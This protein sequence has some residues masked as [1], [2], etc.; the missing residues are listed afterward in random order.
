MVTEL[1]QPGGLLLRRDAI[2]AGYTDKHLRRL[3]LAGRIERIRQ[4]A[5]A[6]SD[7]WNSLDAT[8][9]HD[10]L[11]SAV[12]RQ[13]DDDIALSHGSAVIRVGG[14]SYKLDL[15]R[16]HITH[17]AGVAHHKGQCHVEDITRTDDHWMTSPSRTVIDVSLVYGFEVGVVVADDFLRRDLTTK[18]QLW[19]MYESMKDWPGALIV[20]MVI[21]FS[22]SRSESV[23]ETLG[24]LLMRRLG[25][26]T[27]E[28]QYEVR[29]P[30]GSV[31]GRTDYA[32]PDHKVLGEFDGKVKYERFLRAGETAADA[33]WREKRRED[34][35]RELTGFA[36][37]RLVWA[38]LF[39]VEETARRLILLLPMA[40]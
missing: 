9:Q 29:R 23:G 15:A 20:R 24:R 17:L 28:L 25:L 6:H 27:P 7:A 3:V 4:G 32:W 2:S 26:P 18:A 12:M 39:K 19:R 14:P 38:D 37:F 13:Y 30:D 8:G 40:A 5:Y 36:F 10:L 1:T 22:D 33:V 16:V 21:A 34:E 35:L 31:A 11:S